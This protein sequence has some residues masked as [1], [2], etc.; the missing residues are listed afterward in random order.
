MA[1][2]WLRTYDLRSP[3]STVATWGTR[4]VQ[5]IAANPFNSQQFASS[6]EDGIVR[7]WDL[8]RPMD[9][10]V[11]FSEVDAGAV[12]AR[13]RPT[14]I[15]KPLIEIK[16]SQTRKG[17][18]TTLE[19]DGHSLRVWQ[20]EDGPS[21]K[22]EGALEGAVGRGDN[23]A[24]EGHA[25]TAMASV[26][27]RMP[28]VLGDR[29]R[30]SS[31]SGSL[32][33]LLTSFAVARSFQQPLTSF[34]II[35]SPMDSTATHFLGV[36]RDTSSPGTSGHRLEV[37]HL[38][39]ARHAAFLDR[40]LLVSSEAA[41]S[42]F[43]TFHIEPPPPELPF[44]GGAEGE[45]PEGLKKHRTLLARGR[46]LSLNVASLPQ[47]DRN[48]TPRP[49][50]SV[51]PRRLSRTGEATSGPAEEDMLSRSGLAALSTDVSVTLRQNVERGYGS[52]VSRLARVQRPLK[53][54]ADLASKGHR[55]CF[56]LRISDLRVLVMDSS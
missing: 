17:I 36:S 32:T 1:G 25:Q 20:I 11:S 27:L 3:P 28:V 22:L 39:S 4:A 21:A 15:A 38:P 52:D 24:Y 6:G 18:L 23:N 40:G 10:L 48:L 42:G 50:G 13:H 35:N 8:R 55:E 43:S 53:S 5:S 34:A 56:S 41:P 37:I 7:L 2:K 51:T 33:C 31:F 47:F 45:S 16:W 44:A 26:G 29:R 54:L 14:V 12:S 49:S 9:A 30:K 46:T 19:R